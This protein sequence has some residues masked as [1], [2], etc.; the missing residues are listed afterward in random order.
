MPRFVGMPERLLAIIIYAV[1]AYVAI[2]IFGYLVQRKMLYFPD[3]RSREAEAERARQ[4]GLLLWPAQ[5]DDYYGLVSADLPPGSNGVIVIFHGNAG[6][7]ADRFYYVGVLQRLGYRVVLYEYPGYGARPGEM[8]ENVFVSDGLRAARAAVTEF[9]GP[10]YLWGESLGCG[11]ASAVAA[12]M[13]PAAAGVI[14]VMPWDT[15]PNIAQD[16]YWALPTKLLVRDRYDNINN[17]RDFKGPIA[18]VM[19]GRD[20]VIPNKRTLNLYESLPEGRRLWTLESAGHN[21]WPLVVG[22][23]W[24]RE[25]MDFAAGG[26]ALDS[27]R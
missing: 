7:A 15:L 25:V 20:D 19:A 6:S 5:S 16:V 8:S 27:K 9:G 1:I 2:I 26:G 10:L 23:G 22:E 4:H 14:L 11:I 17:L 18:V 21:D 24:W 13:E 12:G 3:R